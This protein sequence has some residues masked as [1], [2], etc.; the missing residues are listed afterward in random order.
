VRIL[1]LRA[2]S[3]GPLKGS[4][5]FHRDR[6]TVLVDDNERGKS[7]LLAAIAAGLYGL[8]GDKRTHRMMSPLERWRPWH[9]GPYRIELEVDTGDERYTILRD[10]DAGSTRVMNSRG[11]EVTDRF[12]QGKDEYRVGDEL[13]GLDAAEFEKCALVRQGELDQ[14]VPGDERARRA[15]TLHGRLENAAD[16]HVGD[17]NATEAIQVLDQALR[18]YTCAELDTTTSVDHAIKALEAKVG[19]VR[20]EIASL[21][22]DRL[23][24]AEPMER[25]ATLA[26]EERTVREGLARLDAE[27]KGSLAADVRRQ[28]D[29][30]AEQRSALAKLRDEARALESAS[31]VPA[32]AEAELRET[33]ARHEEA[34]RNLETLEA[35]RREELQRERGGLEGESQALAAYASSSMAD[36]DRLVALAADIRRIAAEGQRLK[37]E[38][39]SFRDTL[40]G[41]GHEPERI[42]FLT[43]RFGAL[44]EDQQSLLRNQSSLAL[45]YQTEVAGLEQARTESTETL[46]AIDGQRNAQR[47]PGWIMVAIGVGAAATGGVVL[48]LHGP[49]SLGGIVLGLGAAGLAAGAWML[50]GAARARG[51]EREDALRRLSDAQRRLN[52]LRSQRAESEVALTEMSKRF[53]YRDPVELM[54]EW[55]EYARLAEEF[56]SMLRPADRMDS[57]GEQR[58]K[59][60]E[61]V[62]SLL[63]RAGGG[64]PDPAHLEV[65]ASGIRRAHA[66]RQR[67]AE[68]EKSWSWIDEEKRVA[69]ALAHGLRERAV[70]MLRSAGL[71]YDPSRPWSDHFAELAA[72]ARDRGRLALI[73]EQLIPT[74]EKQLRPASEIEDLRS[75]L[76]LIE[77][78]KSAGASPVEESAARSPIEI[79][80]ERER[81]EASRE[82]TE[83][84]RIELKAEIDEITRRY[85][86]Q[87][88]EKTSTAERLERALAHARRFK[89]AAEL[90]RDTIQHVA[91]DTHRRWAE[92]LN[93]RVAELLKVMGTRVVE[94]RFGEDLD[95]SVR[96]WNGQPVAR[97]KAVTQLSAGA[98][99]QLHFAVRLAIAEYLS[100]GPLPLP[101]LIDDAFSTSDDERAR[102]G[103][104]LL[105]EHFSRRHQILIVTCHRQRY[106]ALAALDPELYRDRVQWLE[107]RP[108]DVSS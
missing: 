7:S 69:E 26:E 39:F 89:E 61:E 24:I 56:G 2:E 38:A 23:K 35:R 105:I 80:R 20:S 45:A 91:L 59:V 21:D 13:L 94:L 41:K 74:A 34:Q 96:F 62:R 79:E 1:R 67:L 18:K 75:Q 48:G 29:L 36:A 3:F 40:A 33:V 51:L 43:S 88:P 66:I 19:L 76:A 70:S 63:D 52:Q 85:H 46:R 84:R 25:L 71:T 16:T 14:V 32:N 106:E 82:R 101:F 9:G 99:D 102:A 30:D 57:L 17:T 11:Q 12:R 55:S 78:Q 95:F 10:F 104:K 60:L 81:L 31:H 64:Q 8:D 54:R 37:S 15:S 97:G 107:L 77:S 72:R 92:H 22:H 73:H 93:H 47:M 108:A 86:A 28:L 90:A 49:P 98:R 100:R 87:H 42:Q 44:P 65:A 53:G 6:V 68:L 103:M 5:E 4:W 83:K 50:A 58:K 27:R